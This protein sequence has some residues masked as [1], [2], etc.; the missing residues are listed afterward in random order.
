[1]KT[2]LRLL[3]MAALACSAVGAL[4]AFNPDQ[5]ARPAAPLPKPISVREKGGGKGICPPP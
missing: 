3:G 4:A 1:M 5:K 2:A